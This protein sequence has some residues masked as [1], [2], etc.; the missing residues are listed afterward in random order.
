[1]ELQHRQMTII[2]FGRTKMKTYKKLALITAI[3]G[4]VVLVTIISG[5]AYVNNLIGFPI[6]GILIGGFLLQ[7]F[8]LL[9]VNAGS[10]YVTFKIK[11]PKL[12]G[13]LLILCGGAILALASFLGIPSFL[14]FCASG[15]LALREKPDF[16]S[17]KIA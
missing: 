5:F 2:K 13:I 17:N 11:N 3:L 14:L 15:I 7:V 6:L 10:F 1:M 8:L 4:L 9:V 16:T 12:A